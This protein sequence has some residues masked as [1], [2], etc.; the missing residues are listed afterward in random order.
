MKFDDLQ[1]LIK[2]LEESNL[3]EIEIEEDGRRIRIK[4]PNLSTTQPIVTTVE[5]SHKP[6]HIIKTAEE[7]N[8]QIIASPFVGTFY[9]APGPDAAPFVETGER[10]Q[11]GEVL[12]II[13]AMK[14]MNEIESDIDGIISNILVNNGDPVEFGQPLFKIGT[15]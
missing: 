7:E 12:C 6:S 14:L 3:E 5:S 9:S 1:K 2:V 10:I 8:F 15:L 13:E 11:K 4:K